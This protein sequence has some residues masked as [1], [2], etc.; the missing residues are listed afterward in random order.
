MPDRRHAPVFLVLCLMLCG[1]MVPAAVSAEGLAGPWIS[2][3]TSIS[4]QAVVNESASLKMITY[5]GGL[6]QKQEWK[7]QNTFSATQGNTWRSDLLVGT[8]ENTLTFQYSR[9]GLFSPINL[10]I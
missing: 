5:N 10:R 8:R 6:P 1:I 7:F 9:L 2:S 3:S 4:G